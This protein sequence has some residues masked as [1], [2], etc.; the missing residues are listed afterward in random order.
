MRNLWPPPNE[1]PGGRSLLTARPPGYHCAFRGFSLQIAKAANASVRLIVRLTTGD[2]VDFQ[3]VEFLND[4]LIVNHR[5]LL[6]LSVF[7][8]TFWS[9]PY[10]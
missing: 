9:I 5:R 7:K 2:E 6:Y 1:N 3:L 4:H 8:P 10:G